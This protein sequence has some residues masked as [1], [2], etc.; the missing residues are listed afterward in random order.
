LIAA[1]LLFCTYYSARDGASKICKNKNKCVDIRGTRSLAS[2][3]FA[4]T[5]N[6]PYSISRLS[7]YSDMSVKPGEKRDFVSLFVHNSAAIPR[8][9]THHFLWPLDSALFPSHF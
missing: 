4:I 2:L 1:L 6:I 5:H 9:D 8:I 7:V 3:T